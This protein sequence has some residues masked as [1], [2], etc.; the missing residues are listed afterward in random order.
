MEKD[1]LSDRFNQPA[2]S[3]F[4][5]AIYGRVS[6]HHHRLQSTH[7]DGARFREFQL[8]IQLRAKTLSCLVGIEFVVR[9]LG[10]FP[11]HFA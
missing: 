5:D 1:N 6:L 2:Q 4:L 8:R 7:A 10:V 11:L 3:I 9:R